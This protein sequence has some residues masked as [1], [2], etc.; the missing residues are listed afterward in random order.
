MVFTAANDH[1]LH[2]ARYP[3]EPLS[4][5][6]AQIAGMQPAFAID[7]GDGSLRVVV[8][9]DHH[10]VGSRAN[11]AHFTYWEHTIIFR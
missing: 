1:V 11:L 6:R 10:R 3:H 7:G 4:V 9:A 8:I 5:H 2:T